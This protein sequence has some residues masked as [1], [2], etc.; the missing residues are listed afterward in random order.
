MTRDELLNH[1]KKELADL[2]RQE[3]I[4]GWHGM[5]KNELVR[6]I[7]RRQRRNHKKTSPARKSAAASLTRKNPP[8]ATERKKAPLATE[9]KNSPAPHTRKSAPLQ[10]AA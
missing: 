4:A 5:R 7:Q 6:A 2:A 9:R 3:G 10:T 8:L 1:T